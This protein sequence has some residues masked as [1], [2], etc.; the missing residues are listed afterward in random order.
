MMSTL[1]RTRTVIRHLNGENEEVSAEYTKSIAEIR[2]TGSLDF[3]ALGWADDI[4]V[5]ILLKPSRHPPFLEIR[6]YP[7]GRII[8][9]F[10]VLGHGENNVAVLNKVGAEESFY[11]SAFNKFYEERHKNINNIPLDLSISYLL[12]NLRLEEVIND[13]M[14]CC[15]AI[16]ALEWQ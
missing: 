11:A 15:A 7:G 9:M 2:D 12:I 3:E 13:I 6:R 16:N 4:R 5:V 1:E 10:V 14:I 8:L